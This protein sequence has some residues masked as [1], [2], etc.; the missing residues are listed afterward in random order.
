ML[1]FILDWFCRVSV[2]DGTETAEGHGSK[3]SPAAYHWWKIYTRSER[4]NLSACTKKWE[5]DWHWQAFPVYVPCMNLVLLMAFYQD[6]YIYY[7][8]YYSYILLHNETHTLKFWTIIPFQH[9]ACRFELQKNFHPLFVL[10][11]LVLK[12]V[13]LNCYS[14]WYQ[15]SVALPSFVMY[16]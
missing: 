15:T 4:P 9:H 1:A 13:G 16:F 7:S 2:T 10:F 5:T 11:H 12:C 14:N 8:Y 6:S 3:T